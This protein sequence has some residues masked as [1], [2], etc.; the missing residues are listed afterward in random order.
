MR[1][2]ERDVSVVIKWFNLN[3]NYFFIQE[4]IEE[5]D[6]MKIEFK[7]SNLEI[8][9]YLDRLAC[10]YVHMIE[11]QTSAVTWPERIRPIF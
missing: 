2:G 10:L 4:F 9:V 5:F 11:M 3:Q 7:L 1:Q 6:F 8:N